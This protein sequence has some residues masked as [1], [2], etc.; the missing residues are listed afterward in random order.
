MQDLKDVGNK[1][2]Q[3]I[4]DGKAKDWADAI[5]DMGQGVAALPKRSC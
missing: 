2:A 1:V 4:A 3:V 5:K